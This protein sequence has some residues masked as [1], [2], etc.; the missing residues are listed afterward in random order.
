MNQETETLEFR[1]GAGR[2]VT[3]LVNQIID[4]REFTHCAVYP[5][6]LMAANPHLSAPDLSLITADQAHDEVFRPARW[7]N[8]RRWMCGETRH[9]GGARPNADGRDPLALRL[10]AANRDLSLRDMARLLKKHG[11]QRGR[12]WVRVNRV[13][14]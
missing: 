6:L 7:I 8:K 3:R 14:D 10:L 4:I 1:D 9:K 5:W 12:E 2:P 11:I 13:R